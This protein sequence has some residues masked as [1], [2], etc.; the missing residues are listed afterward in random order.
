MWNTVYSVCPEH[1]AYTTGN[2]CAEYPVLRP[3]SCV[4]AVR[5]V[6]IER[7]IN[8]K[9]SLLTQG[10]Q[11]WLCT[12]DIPNLKREYVLVEYKLF[13]TRWI[14][15]DD[16]AKGLKVVKTKACTALMMNSEKSASAETCLQL[17]FSILR[18]NPKSHAILLLA[19]QQTLEVISS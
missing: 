14:V 2:D 12:T 5:I 13:Q 4:K 16:Q 7:T 10:R 19:H 18:S 17:L 15:A 3:E 11:D 1:S 6:Q 9:A 8:C